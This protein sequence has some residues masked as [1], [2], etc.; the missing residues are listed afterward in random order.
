[1]SND[2][3]A[4]YCIKDCFKEVGKGLLIYVVALGLFW[5]IV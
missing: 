5:W 4:V 3:F 2:E 1:M